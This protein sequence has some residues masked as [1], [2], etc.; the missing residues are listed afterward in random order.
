M[1]IAGNAGAR[2]CCAAN[3][4]AATTAKAGLDEFRGLQREAGEVDPAPR[5]LDLDADDEGERGQ[6][7]ARSTKPI[8][9]Q[10][11]ARRAARSS[12]TPS[13]IAERRPA[14]ARTGGA[15]DRSG[16]GRCA[17]RPP[18]WPPASGSTPKH[19]QHAE[20]R[21]RPA[22]DGPPPAAEDAAVVRAE[23]GSCRPPQTSGARQRARHG[24]ERIAALPRN[25]RTG[26][27]R[28]RPATAAPP[29]RGRRLAL[30]HAAC[31]ASSARLAASPQRLYGDAGPRAGAA[32][33]S[34][35]SPI[36]KAW[37]DA[38]EVGLE[39][40]RCRPPSAWPPSDPV[41]RRRSRR[42]ALAAASALVALLSLT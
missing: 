35:A 13:M 23:P 2:P 19:D 38:A 25:R 9:R 29:R 21:Q 7:R 34:V 22:V 30:R 16:R 42:S 39:R 11:A 1:Q 10:R 32:N 27:T 17:R 40:R 5:A 12:E 36:R 20:R 33:C 14:A 31:A 8:T 18:G 37:R 6:R 41:D 24:A 4:Q 26:R 28:R 15:R 3:S